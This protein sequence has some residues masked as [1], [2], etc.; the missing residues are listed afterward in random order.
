MPPVLFDWFYCH[1]KTG[2]GEKSIALN[3]VARFFLTKYT[4]TREN[5]PNY[6]YITK[7][8][9]NARKIFQNGNKIDQQFL[10]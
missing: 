2:G 6:H 9:P 8:P 4:K 5:I 10:F 7:W 3:R 1:L